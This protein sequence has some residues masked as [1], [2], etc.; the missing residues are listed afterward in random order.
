MLVFLFR[1]A[2]ILGQSTFV[3]CSFLLKIEPKIILAS[4]VGIHSLICLMNISMFLKI[5]VMPITKKHVFEEIYVFDEH[6]DFLTNN[7]IFDENVDCFTNI[8][9][10]LTNMFF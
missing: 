6:F 5:D 1:F 3:F 8:L 10:C 7:V 4:H 9:I 2:L